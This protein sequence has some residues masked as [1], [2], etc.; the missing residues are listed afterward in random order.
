MMAGFVA[1]C[2]FFVYLAVI[3]YLVSLAS[4]L[5]MAVER[6]AHRLEQLPS[7]KMIDALDRIAGNVELTP[8]MDLDKWETE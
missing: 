3:F 2:A 5:V 4:R 8:D 1:L 7:R 6:I